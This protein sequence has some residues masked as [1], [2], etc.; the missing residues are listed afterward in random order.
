[1]Q[2]SKN[3][4]EDNLI[5]KKRLTDF[6]EWFN[7]LTEEQITVFLDKIDAIKKEI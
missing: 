7:T 1:M 3:L 4:Y 6:L 5:L 2:M